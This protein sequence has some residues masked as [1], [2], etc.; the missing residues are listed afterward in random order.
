MILSHSYSE[1]ILPLSISSGSGWPDI[2]GN[3][4]NPNRSPNFNANLDP[5]TIPDSLAS[6]IDDATYYMTVGG[7]G[8]EESITKEQDFAGELNLSYN[9]N[10]SSDINIKLSMGGKLKHK[11]KEYDRTALGI[12]SSN[13]VHLVHDMFYDE[14]SDRTKQAFADND[15]FLYADDIFWDQ[16]YD[17]SHLGD[18]YNFSPVLDAERY[19]QIHDEAMTYYDPDGPVD[20]WSLVSANFIN[21]DYSAFY[22]MPEINLGSDLLFIP[23]VRYESN[24]TE[25]TGYRGNRLGVLRDWTRTPIDTLTKTRYNDFWLPMI[26]LF[27]TPTDWMTIKA[28]YTHTLQRPDYNNI[29]PGYVI[30]FQG[31]INNLSNFRLEPEESRNSDLQFSFHSDKIGLLS[32][33]VF[34]KE[35]KNMI[36]WTGM[37]VITD[38]AYFELPTLMYRQRA[39]YATNNQ[40]PAT[41][42]GFEVEWQS[43]FWWLPGLLSGLVVNVNYTRNWSEAE[44][45]R[46]TIRVEIDPITYRSTQ[47]SDDTTYTSPMIS[48]PDHLLNLTLGYDYKGFSIRWAMR[49]TSGIFK[50][51]NWYEAL[52]GYSTEFIRYDLSLKQQLP[53]TGLEVFLNVNNLTGEIEKDIIEHNSYSRYLEDYGRTANFGVRYIF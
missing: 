8:H 34:H 11:T 6:S 7:Q 42:Y 49:Y 32:A 36:F 44:Y 38:T 20:L 13:Y 19:L 37:T 47:I 31:Q 23:G 39:V 27:Y 10:I 4:F 24:R 28:G 50:S 21:T 43:N 48:Q 40:Y 45:L 3:P 14:L 46:S 18:R 52:R 41:N 1:N 53:V 30:S 51:T 12:G 5:E 29:M 25:Y 15:Q 33:G 26:Q 2:S 35:I 17:R 16:D 22:F 9:F